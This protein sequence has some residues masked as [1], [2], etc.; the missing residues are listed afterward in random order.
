MGCVLRGELPEK[1]VAPVIGYGGAAYGGKTDGLLGLAIAAAFAYPGVNIGFA[2]RTFP[3]LNMLGG[4]I[5]RS[6]EILAG[7]TAY[8]I[9]EHVHVFPSGSKLQFIYAQNEADVLKYKSSQYDILLIDEATTFTWYM[10]DYLMT[11][12]RATISG[13]Q[14]FTV[15]TTNPGDVG[16]AWYMQVFDTVAAYGAHMQVKQ[17]ENPNGKTSATYFIPAFLT[18]NTIGLRRDPGYGD[19]LAERDPETARALLAGDWTV[20]AGQAFPQWRHDRHVRPWH[21]LPDDWPTWRSFDYGWTHPYYTYWW[22]KNPANGRHYLTRE[23]HGSKMTDPEIAEAIKTATLPRE[24]ILFTFASPDMWRAQRADHIVTTAP[25]TFARAGIILTR[26][27][28]HRINGKQKFN[29]L[30]APLEDGEPG[31]VVFDTCPDFI[32]LM[33]SLVRDPKNPED[34][35]KV[36]GDDPY[37]AARYGLTNMAAP[38]KPDHRPEGPGEQTRKAMREVFA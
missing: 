24:R 25:D 28:D 38:R 17:V 13:I 26:A 1:P 23:L 8:N 18:D 11:R 32:K 3:E 9:S 30:L 6:Q 15:M 34:V 10:V 5:K 7:V 36:D 16:H 22:K 20:F 37:D 29:T 31:L 14:P 12:N 35:L 27:D 19:R 33:P 4:A 21:D 2:R